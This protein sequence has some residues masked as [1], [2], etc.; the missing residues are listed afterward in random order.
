MLGGCLPLDSLTISSVFRPN[1]Y[2]QKRYNRVI[3][4]SSEVFTIT[5]KPTTPIC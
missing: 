2:I 1:G 4:Y 3:Q 5:A